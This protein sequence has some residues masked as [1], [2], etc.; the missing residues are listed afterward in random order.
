[1]LGLWRALAGRCAEARALAE[2]TRAECPADPLPELG[3]SGAGDTLQGLGIAC[4]ALGQVDAARAAFAQARDIFRAIDQHYQWA[5]TAAWELDEVVLPYFTDQPA[6]RRHLVEEAEQAWADTS[7]MLEEVDPA[8]ARLPLMLL[9]GGWEEA[10]RI[11]REATH[12]RGI[13]TRRLLAV[14]VLGQLALYRGET[15]LAWAQVMAVLPDGPETVPGDTWLTTAIALQR[16]AAQLALQ[17]GERDRARAWLEAHDRWL[18][19]SG[20]VLGRADGELCWAGY[21]RAAGELEPARQR[22]SAALRE[23]TTPRQPLVL[24][25]AHRL[26]GQLDIA[27]G[28]PDSACSHLEAALTL[29]QA[30]DVPY[31]RALTLL[32]LAE[33]CTATGR[34][35]EA[36]RLIDEARPI[37]ASLGAT[38]VLARCALLAAEPGTGPR[39]TAYPGNLSAREVEVLRLVAHGLTNIEVAERL[40]LSPRTVEQHLR[41]VYNKLGVSS[42]ASATRFAV[43][44]HLIY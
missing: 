2:R 18:A 15:E 22:A 41:S 6:V 25:A 26:I 8:I 43:E 4:A 9:S 29:A 35:V 17:A 32:A 11:A 31:E 13:V 27:E 10:S 1:M 39:A 33:A 14:R 5:I 38:P 20:S 37:A 7:G 30:C 28:R 40:V 3:A 12:A 19:W 44:Q 42:R 16:V 34:H 21:H 24:L 23:A 36:R